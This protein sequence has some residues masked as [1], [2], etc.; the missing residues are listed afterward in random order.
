MGHVYDQMME[1]VHGQSQDRRNWAL[2]SFLWLICAKRPVST[3]ELIHAVG[4]KVGDTQLDQDALPLASDVL[5]A[6][7]GFTT[8]N[9][10]GYYRFVHLT[11][12]E[13]I[14]DKLSQWFPDSSGELNL[15]EVCVTYLSFTDFVGGPCPT[16][17]EF[18]ARCRLYRLYHY[19]A[20]NW[21]HHAREAPVSSEPIM[22]FLRSPGNTNAS[23]QALLRPRSGEVSG[24]HLAAYFGLHRITDDML[25]G[26]SH[27]NCVDSNGQTPL[28]W[29]AQND[30]TSVV[31][32]L[33][34]HD[35]I[36]LHAMVTAG[37]RA[38][39][40]MILDAGYK[41]NTIDFWRRTAL[42]LA[43]SSSDTKLAHL[44]ILKGVDID[45]EDINGHT[46]L[47]LALVNNK[48]NFVRLLL[49][50][51]ANTKRI[52]LENW[53]RAFGQ[54]ESV[55]L[56]LATDV[57]TGPTIGFHS[58]LPRFWAVDDSKSRRSLM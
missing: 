47:E 2:Q 38:L 10:D 8:D 36:T 29:A 25:A 4:V 56:E 7:Q 28:W 20:A 19:A 13:Y 50:A 39:V 53:R 5:S 1:K 45:A 3:H 16:E 27:P 34:Q 30:R 40:K 43:L 51:S 21:G 46:A 12:K 58:S 24:L 6:S 23:C 55:V 33:D 15:A 48:Q 26:G 35:N 22:Q 18:E 32:S 14:A 41:I 37:E 57:G 52:P 17:A 31:E 42:Y 11:A 49:E 54:D 9:G 44:L